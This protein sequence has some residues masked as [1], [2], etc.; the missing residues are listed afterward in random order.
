MRYKHFAVLIPI[1]VLIPA[2]G[3][4]Q[5]GFPDFPDIDS[6]TITASFMAG[7]LTF[8]SPCVLPLI[9]IYLTMLAG[10]KDEKKRTASVIKPTLAFIA[11][12]CIVFTLLGITAGIAGQMLGK[13]QNWIRLIGGFLVVIFGAHIAGFFRIM[14]FYKDIRWHKAPSPRGLLGACLMGIIFA[15]GWTPCVGP[16]LA[17]ILLLS[18]SQA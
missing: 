9:P 15:A 13:F 5:S 4:A 6:I 1:L 16:I 10:F 12:F 17:S 3:H 18:A 7:I 8:F 11:G 14:P 2:I